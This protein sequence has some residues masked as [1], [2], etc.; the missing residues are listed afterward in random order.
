MSFI[1][2]EM[3]RMKDADIFD[4]TFQKVSK[5]ESDSLIDNTPTH[6]FYK[7]IEIGDRKGPIPIDRDLEFGPPGGNIMDRPN[8]NAQ[9]TH[10]NIRKENNSVVNMDT[11]LEQMN[12]VENKRTSTIQQNIIQKKIEEFNPVREIFKKMKKNKKSININLALN[13]PDVQL[14]E[15]LNSSFDDVERILIEYILSDENMIDMK[16]SLRNSMRTYY[17]LEVLSDEEMNKEMDY[18]SDVKQNTTESVVVDKIDTYTVDNNE[19]LEE[20]LNISID[21]FVKEDSL[22]NISLKPVNQSNNKIITETN[23]QQINR[24]KDLLKEFN[25]P[26]FS[27]P[28]SQLIDS[29]SNSSLSDEQKSMLDKFIKK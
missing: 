23:E 21:E 25:K 27:N 22:Q 4:G 24:H 28:Q 12:Y 26:N 7:K 17:G 2:N 3:L 9:P 11:S 20:D 29:F 15:T 14:F 16:L 10:L 13:I 19:E 18:Y 8:Y 1:E 6:Q 5:Q